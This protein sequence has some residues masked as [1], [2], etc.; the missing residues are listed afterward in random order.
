[1][2]AFLNMA[3]TGLVLS[4]AAALPAMAQD[5]QSSP[6]ERIN[7]LIIYGE[8]KC[9]ESKG[10]EIV[11]C[12]R[13]GEAERY[14]I[15]TTLRTGAASV[16]KDAWTNRVKSYE[17]AGASGTMSCSPVGAGGFTGCGLR[18]INDAYAEKKEDAGLAFGR[19]IAAERKKRLG[20]IDAESEAVEVRVK[21][22]ETERAAREAKEEAA[23]RALDE[24]DKSGVDGEPLPEPK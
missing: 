2:R 22:F 24:R 7:Q 6:D 10:D 23:Q 20:G 16:S 15:P 14:R 4:A 1:V 18:E 3:L 13:L 11:V 17:Y 12:A 9:P 21:Q 5:Q 19:M 8:D